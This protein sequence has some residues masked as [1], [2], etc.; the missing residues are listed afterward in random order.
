MIKKATLIFKPYS[1]LLFLDNKIAGAILFALSFL[2]PSVG[3]S[4]IFAVFTTI[5]FAELITLREE[6]LGVYLSTFTR[7]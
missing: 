5:I 3:I 1:A 4:G 7:L 2:I 6:V